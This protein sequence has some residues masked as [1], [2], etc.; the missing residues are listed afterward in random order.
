MKYSSVDLEINNQTDFEIE[1]DFFRHIFQEVIALVS[2]ECLE[3]KKASISVAFIDQEEIARI[4]EQYRQRKEPTDVLSFCEHE[5]ISDLC[6]NKDK[7]VF[8]GEILICPEYIL[9]S[10]PNFGVSFEYELAYIFSHGILHLLG[11]EHG[12]KMFG[13]Q[14]KIAQKF[15]GDSKFDK[16][17]Q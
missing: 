7:E 4:N 15:A 13:L 10:A 2:M 6:H 14:E 12:E 11:F 5:K 17:K 1:P 8:L 9:K 16:I 3:G